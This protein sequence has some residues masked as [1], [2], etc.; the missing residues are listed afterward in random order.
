MN[1]EAV[2]AV[3]E[4]V[5]AFAVVLTLGYLAV[6]VRQ[7]TMAA[8]IAAKQ[9]MTRQFSDYSDLLLQA[10]NLLDVH[11]QGLRDEE[12]EKPGRAQFNL[13]MQKATWYF[14][15]MHFQYIAHSLSDEEWH[16]SR[17]MIAAYCRTPGFENWWNRNR[18]DYSPRF[19]EFLDEHWKGQDSS[20]G[21]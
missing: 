16:Q 20:W 13:L 18:H 12:L 4:L 5:G 2:G 9:E 17:S 8:R 1:W 15:S 6:Q 21:G 11:R 14:A 3:G 7:S 19:V 10:P